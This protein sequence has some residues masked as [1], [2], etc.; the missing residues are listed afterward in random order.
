M[1]RIR[2]IKPEFWRHEDLSELPEATHLLAAALLN[3]ADDEGYFN[4]N[5]KLIQAECCPLREPSVSIQDSLRK[6]SNVGYLKLGTGED[7]KQYGRIEKFKEH[8]RINRPT[9]SKINKLNI[10]WDG[11]Q[12]NHQQL[13]EP[14]SPE[15]NRE[16][17]T[18]KGSSEPNGSG[19]DAPDWKALLFSESL[20]FLSEHYDK[21]GDK[22]RSLLGKWRMAL[23]EDCEQLVAIIREAEVKRMADPVE[24]I[25]AAVKTRKG[26]REPQWKRDKQ[27]A[28]EDFMNA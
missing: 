21:P 19:A 7:G 25:E 15:R 12:S 24:W 8:Q 18:G 3:Y 13:S 4:A 17:G 11:S 1:A 9:E 16:Q 26:Q 6:L 22:F 10:T 23:D 28:A 20:V 27:Q 2:T 5:P 14:S